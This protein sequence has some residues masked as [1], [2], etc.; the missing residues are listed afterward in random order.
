MW[1][2]NLTKNAKCVK[3]GYSNEI[4]AVQGESNTDTFA[5][6]RID[7]P[8]SDVIK[9]ALGSNQL[10]MKFRTNLDNLI[11]SYLN[12]LHVRRQILKGD[13]YII[14]FNK[15]YTF[16]SSSNSVIQATI[17]IINLITRINVKLLKKN[18]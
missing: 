16:S 18:K 14:R 5:V 15:D 6:L 17:E 3:C 10:F 8:N 9:S 1:K 2:I 7:F 13:T 12:S 11:V 4:S